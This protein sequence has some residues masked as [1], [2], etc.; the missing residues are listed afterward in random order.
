VRSLRRRSNARSVDDLDISIDHEISNIF[1]RIWTIDVDKTYPGEPQ[2]R[3]QLGMMVNPSWLAGC[4]Q[5]AETSRSVCAPRI[6]LGVKA[7]EMIQ[8][9]PSNS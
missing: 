1:S 6:R 2:R 9:L 8:V 4:I 5:R 3:K 7:E